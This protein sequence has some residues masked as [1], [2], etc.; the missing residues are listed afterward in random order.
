[1]KEKLTMKETEQLSDICSSIEKMSED[2]NNAG[3]L[4][5]DYAEIFTEGKDLSSVGYDANNEQYKL[6]I[7]IDYVFNVHD[8]LKEALSSLDAVIGGAVLREIQQNDPPGSS[9]DYIMKV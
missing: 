5:G 1:M 9:A 3:Q 7:V 4:L 6:W 2:L 8:R